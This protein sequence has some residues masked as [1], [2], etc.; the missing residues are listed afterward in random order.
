MLAID[1]INVCHHRLSL[2]L[3]E[4]NCIPL[5]SLKILHPTSATWLSIP[6]HR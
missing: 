5:V 6:N 1:Y 3:P 2:T 4:F